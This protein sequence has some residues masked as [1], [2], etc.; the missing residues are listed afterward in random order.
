MCASART[1][2]SPLLSRGT[3]GIFYTCFYK[4]AR[5]LRLEKILF[6]ELSRSPNGFFNQFWIQV[7]VSLLK[8]PHGGFISETAVT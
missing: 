1:Y 3:T 2:F 7:V 8:P 6:P 5:R 4:H